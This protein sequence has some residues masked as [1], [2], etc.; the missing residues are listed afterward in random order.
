MSYS[1]IH[2]DNCQERWRKGKKWEEI[3]CINHESRLD[4]MKIKHLIKQIALNFT[5]S[6]IVP[7]G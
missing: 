4:S 7:E 5:V 3:N 2:H 1:A 6:Y